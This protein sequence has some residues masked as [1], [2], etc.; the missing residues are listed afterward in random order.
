M[1]TQYPSGNR[2]VVLVP[3]C[4]RMLGHHPYFIAGKKYIDAVRLAGCLPLM[5]PSAPHEDEDELLNLCQGLLL[6]GSPSNV[7]PSYFGEDVLDPSLPLDEQRDGL[8]LP[9]IRRALQRGVPI[10]AI[11]RGLQE[12]NV[13][14]GGSLHQAIHSLPG[15][16]DHREDASHDIETQYGPAHTVSVQAGGVLARI[17]GEVDIT[18]NSLH[19]QGIRTLAPGLRAEALSPD[20]VVEAFSP[21]GSEGFCLGVQWHPEWRAAENPVSC[22]LFAAFGAACQ[23]YKDRHRPPQR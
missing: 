23:D 14:L 4:N 12:V 22:Q 20:G 13:A 17:L 8:T 6:P 7:N 2:P 1:S 19:G 21:I 15:K 16:R 5:L 10:F 3:S 11:C 18:V 9:L